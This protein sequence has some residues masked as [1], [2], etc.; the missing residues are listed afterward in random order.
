MEDMTLPWYELSGGISKGH[1]G[2]S[3]AYAGILRIRHHLYMHLISFT[4]RHALSQGPRHSRLQIAPAYQHW[5]LLWYIAAAVETFVS[6]ENTA[7]RLSILPYRAT[8]VCTSVFTYL[9]M[10]MM[11]TM[12][13]K[14]LGRGRVTKPTLKLQARRNPV[15]QAVQAMLFRNR[16]LRSRTI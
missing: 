9:V 15:M 12:G 3:V 16:T 7:Q 2:C 8:I 4:N 1:L 10:T 5:S 13:P 11:W 14:F 6:P